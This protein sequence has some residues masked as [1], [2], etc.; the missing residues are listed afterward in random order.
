MVAA[1]AQRE[2]RRGAYKDKVGARLVYY[3]DIGITKLLIAIDSSKYLDFISIYRVFYLT[4]YNKVT[5]L[6]KISKLNRYYSK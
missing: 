2:E 4:S 3:K 6:Y 5:F 1:L